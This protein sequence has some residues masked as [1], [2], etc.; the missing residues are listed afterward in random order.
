[1]RQGVDYL[2]AGGL[3]VNA[4]A[5]LRFTADIDLVIALNGDKTSWQ[6]KTTSTGKNHW[7]GSRREQLRQWLTLSVRERLQSL[8]VMNKLAAHFSQMRQ[9]GKFRKPE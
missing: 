9:Q 6:T 1:M 2:I 3:A 8:D 7:E 5:Y 4:H